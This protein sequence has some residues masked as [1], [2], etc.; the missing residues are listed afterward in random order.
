MR[1]I[2]P[3]KIR[4]P[5]FAFNALTNQMRALGFGIS[6]S[7]SGFRSYSTQHGLYWNYVRQYGQA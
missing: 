7:Y 4:L 5:K 6:Y 2:I 1:P 3:G